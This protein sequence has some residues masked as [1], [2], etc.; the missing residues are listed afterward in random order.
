LLSSSFTMVLA[1]YGA[2]TG[3]R[4]LLLGGLALTLLLGAAFLAIKV[5]EYALDYHDGLVPLPGWFTAAGWTIPER[6]TAEP[7]RF[8]ARVRLFYVIYFVMT[9]LHAV[10]MI[11]GMSVLAVLLVLAWRGWFTPDYHPQV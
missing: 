2:Q 10:H 9:G 8:L 3:R 7:E 5:A 1:V 6:F 11:A 4:R